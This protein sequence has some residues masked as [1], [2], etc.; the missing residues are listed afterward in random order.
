MSDIS[1]DAFGIALKESFLTNNYV[2]YIIERDDGNIECRSTENYFYK[3]ENWSDS[4]KRVL[5]YHKEKILDIGSGAGRHSHYLQNKGCDVTAIDVSEGAAFVCK[6]R[7]IK[8]VICTSIFNLEKNIENNDKFQSV[9]LLGNNF[10]IG[11]SIEGTKLLL[12]LLDN[13]T[14][15]DANIITDFRDP[16]GTKNIIHLDYHMKNRKNNK[17]I[18]LL[19]IRVRY[20]KYKTD[21]FPLYCPTKSEYLDLIEKTNWIVEKEL[22]EKS[23]YYIVLNK[24][25]NNL[26]S[27][28]F[29]NNFYL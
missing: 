12:K 14:T 9:I 23:M 24:G 21:W 22:I 29:D 25:S 20:Q 8:K 19:S 27:K 13:I 6:K 3:E 2:N 11:G 26:N 7:G 18:G 28:F 17:P 4:E 1:K 10:G 5:S 16:S 15:P